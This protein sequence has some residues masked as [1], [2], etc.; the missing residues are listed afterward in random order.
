MSI[1]RNFSADEKA[2]LTTLIR[3]GVGIMDEVK[4]LNE[5]L[6][7]TVKAIAEELEIKTAVLTKAIKTAYKRDFDK[8]EA[9]TQLLEEILRQTGNK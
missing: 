2:R 1:P 5:G 7:E 6:S 3:D 9:D 4:S 8:V